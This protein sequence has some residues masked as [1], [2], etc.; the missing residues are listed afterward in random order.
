MRVRTIL[1]S[2]KNRFYVTVDEKI[3]MLD[4]SCPL[5]RNHLQYLLETDLI[6]KQLLDIAKKV[7]VEVYV[8]PL[9][10]AFGLF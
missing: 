2:C 5:E 3:G 9:F 4:E 6:H 10:F 1:L 8:S 7:H